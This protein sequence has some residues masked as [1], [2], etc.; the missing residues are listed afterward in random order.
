MTYKKMKITRLL[1]IKALLC[2]T[3]HIHYYKDSSSKC[4]HSID[5]LHRKIKNVCMHNYSS[6]FLFSFWNKPMYPGR[7]CTV[8]NDRLRWKT[9]IYGGRTQDPYTGTVYGVKRWETDTVYG[10]RIKNRSDLKVTVST[11]YT[12]LYDYR[13]RSYIIVC[14]RIRSYTVTVWVTF[15]IHT[16]S[17]WIYKQ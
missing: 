15:Q 11:P 6:F 12:E 2:K 7:T 9:E 14:C 8:V 13:I 4:W 3:Y 10:D 17:E 5:S 1:W 16:G